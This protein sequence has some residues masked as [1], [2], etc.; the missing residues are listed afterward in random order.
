MAGRMV[1]WH[2]I[3]S[4]L[5]SVGMSRRRSLLA[6]WAVWHDWHRIRSFFGPAWVPAAASAAGNTAFSFVSG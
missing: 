1:S 3:Q 2:E 6:P 4:W 5:A